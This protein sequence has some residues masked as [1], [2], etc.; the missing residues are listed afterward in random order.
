MWIALLIVI[1]L[2]L[3]GLLYIVFIGWAFSS[4][5]RNKFGPEW[6]PIELGLEFSMMNLVEKKDG[7]IA[8][9][10]QTE[11]I[12]RLVLTID[13]AIKHDKQIG[14]G[15]WSKRN[16]GVYEFTAIGKKTPR[17][18]LSVNDKVLIYHP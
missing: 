3:F 8:F 16:D 1:L 11:E 9:S 10:F 17:A 6:I 15:S 18:T 12:E 4:G 5:F 13:H 14:K 7:D 2:M